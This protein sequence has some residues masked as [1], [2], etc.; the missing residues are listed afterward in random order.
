[1]EEAKKVEPLEEVID[2]L[3][4]S[5]RSSHIVRLRHGECSIEA[6]FVWA[7]L[8]TTLERTADHCS[9]IAMCLIDSKKNNMNLHESVRN[10]KDD[11]PEYKEQYKQYMEKYMISLV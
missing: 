5:L 11:N 10:I 6:G 2:E 1:M 8:L 3:K 7:D 9:N 4:E